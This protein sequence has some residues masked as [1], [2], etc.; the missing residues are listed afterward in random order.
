M[1][2]GTHTHSGPGN[3]FENNF[4]NDH[5]ANAPGLDT[6]YYEY[7]SQKIAR[8]VIR[9]YQM[10]KPAKIATGKIEIWNVTRNRSLESYRANKNIS[11]ENSP[12]IYEAINPDLYLMRIDALDDNGQYRPLASISSF[13][14]HGTAVPR[15]NELYHGDVF[16]FMEREVEFGIQNTYKI[17]WTPIH[18][19]FNGTHADNS[20]NYSRQSFEEARR[21][22]TI[23]G[24]KAWKLFCSLEGQLKNDIVIRFR[25]RE[26]NL[27][28]EPC[29]AEICLCNRPVVGSALAA[30]ADDGPSPV[31]SKLPWLRQ[32]SPRWFFTNFC[33]GHKRTLGG[34][35]QYLILSK[36]D[37]PHE[38]FLQVLQIG[39]ALLIP[40]PFETTKEAGLRMVSKCRQQITNGSP[41]DLKYFFVISCA[42][43]YFGYMTTPEEYSR[44]R[45][46][47]GH[48]LYGPQTQPFVA[49]Q[50]ERLTRMWEKKILKR[51]YR[52]RGHTG[53]VQN[54]LLIK[55]CR[56][57]KKKS[58]FRTRFD[59]A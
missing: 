26:I 21:I 43:G 56:Q 22:G 53:C 45:Y 42:N 47:G 46:E 50:L 41:H 3:Y 23:I 17:S 54:N 10:K 8:A 12:G 4:Y 13:S 16:A 36:E 19:A 51:P 14:I 5:A 28:S 44:Q 49:A 35:L 20:P 58:T 40:L 33:Q 57:H 6:A 27:F 30:G 11:S 25:T 15:D 55:N 2:A 48:T 34:P 32:G 9:A 1:I 59:P 31:I 7:L 38:L 37:F 18:A 24:K 52:R 39:E 29:A